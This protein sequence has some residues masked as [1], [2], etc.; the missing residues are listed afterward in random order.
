[1]AYTE[2]EIAAGLRRRNRELLDHLIRHYQER[3]MRY[4]VYITG[5]SEAAEDLFQ[6]TWLRV[7]ERGHQY[8]GVTKF[9][10]WLFAIA[11]HLAIDTKRKRES[12]AI[13]TFSHLGQAGRPFEVES[14]RQPSPF[15]TAARGEDARRIAATLGRLDGVS[16][17]AIA[18]RFLEGMKLE[19]IASLLGSP[20]S[21]VKS[22]IYRGLKMLRDELE[23]SES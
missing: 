3:L 18:L 22:R 15:E 19:E 13:D 4:L 7:L 12:T 11:R 16:R 23:Q 9:S 17:E 6:E 20:L 5:R 21:T 14:K 1:M 2:A 10:Y 8:D